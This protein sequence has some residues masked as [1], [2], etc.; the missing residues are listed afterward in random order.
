R[1]QLEVA[2]HQATAVPHCVRLTTM[3]DLAA[4]LNAVQ[5]EGEVP[6]RF[7]PVS[8]LCGGKKLATANRII[9]GDQEPD[10]GKEQ[11]WKT[12]KD[13]RKLL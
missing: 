13:Q 6:K 1:F 9:L 2:I 11:P 7:C 10:L 5:E 3:Q 4:G 12:A 8:D